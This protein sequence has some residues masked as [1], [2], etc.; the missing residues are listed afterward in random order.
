MLEKRHFRRL[1]F[2]IPCHFLWSEKSFEGRV[3]NLSFTGACIRQVRQIPPEGTQITIRM[4]LEPENIS[5]R[6][7]VVHRCQTENVSSAPA[8]GAFFGVE[9]LDPAQERGEKLIPLLK[10]DLPL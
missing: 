8:E 4:Y 7:R 9:F 5:L 2:S 6:A 1:E 10:S 3:V